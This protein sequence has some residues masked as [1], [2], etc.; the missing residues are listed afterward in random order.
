MKLTS[1]LL[2][3]AAAATL[4]LSGCSEQLST[5][6]TCVELRAAIATF[7]DDLDEE[8]AGEAYDEIS[9][10]FLD[11]AGTASD[12][13]ADDIETACN[14]LAGGGGGGQDDDDQAALDCLEKICELD[15]S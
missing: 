6:D 4:T 15:E 9:G 7:P 1:A 14:F 11:L 8:S 2:T 13:L 3:L 12:T 10:K 5:A